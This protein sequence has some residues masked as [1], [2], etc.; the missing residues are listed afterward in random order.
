[1]F[2]CETGS[3][4]DPWSSS[5]PVPQPARDGAFGG[6]AAL[7][8]FGAPAAVT[9][10]GTNGASTIDSEFD[11]LSSRSNENSPAKSAGGH[12]MDEFDLL[13]GQYRNSSLEPHSPTDQ[14]GCPFPHDFGDFCKLQWH[15]LILQK[16][17]IGAKE[18]GKYKLTV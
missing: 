7:D 12:G 9:T 2:H 6:G 5:S 14:Q 3:Q 1:M 10:N 11:L 16:G 8:A 15:I 4:H 18:K 17:K 13:S